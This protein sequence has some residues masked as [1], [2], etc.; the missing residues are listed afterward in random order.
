MQAGTDRCCSESGEKLAAV[1]VV[2]RC[3]SH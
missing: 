3:R 2:A 1:D